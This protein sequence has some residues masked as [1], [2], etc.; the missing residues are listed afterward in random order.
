MTHHCANGSDDNAAAL[1]LLAGELAA[2]G[3]QARLISPAGRPP[4]LAVRNPAAPM[5]A[6]TVFARDGSLWWPW[7][8]RITAV[9]DT[10]GAADVI[11]RVL[12][13]VPPAA[14]Q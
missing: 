8:D 6:E 5:L 3:Y 13:A 7:A 11:A 4:Q 2:R 1:G 12:A 9:T 10:G 14:V